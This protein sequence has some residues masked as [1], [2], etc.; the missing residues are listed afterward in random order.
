VEPKLVGLCP[1]FCCKSGKK[2]Q[3]LIDDGNERFEE[4][5][6]VKNLLA[7]VRKTYEMWDLILTEQQ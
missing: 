4:E 1:S 6:D 3:R 2:R 7:K 5:L